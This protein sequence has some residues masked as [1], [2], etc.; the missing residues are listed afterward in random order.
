MEGLFQCF[1]RKGPVMTGGLPVVVKV[2]A[3]GEIQAIDDTRKLTRMIVCTGFL[4]SVLCE[5]LS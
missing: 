3:N 5:P 4:L 2:T 1:P